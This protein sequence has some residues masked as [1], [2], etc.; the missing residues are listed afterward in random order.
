MAMFE[1][2]MSALSFDDGYDYDEFVED[3]NYE[4]DDVED[5]AEEE[6]SRPKFGNFF[7]RNSDKISDEEPVVSKRRERRTANT[8]SNSNRSSLPKEKTNVVNLNRDADKT[9]VNIRFTSFD[10]VRKITNHLKTGRICIVDLNSIGTKD[11]QRSL[12][13]ICG[14]SDAIDA[15]I[16]RVS[17]VGSLFLI[18]PTGV[19]TI[20]D[21]V[22]DG[23]KKGLFS[24]EN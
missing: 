17:N 2:I 10:D 9:V 11:A 14:V 3:E 23:R 1:K 12:D 16:Q 20:S 5:V 24:W 19:N 15:D 7:L 6:V 22:E 13:F 4:Y 8:S 18:T 21:N